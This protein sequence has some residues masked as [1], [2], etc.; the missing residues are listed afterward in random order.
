MF[1]INETAVVGLC[2][3]GGTYVLSL[4]GL[5]RVLSARIH[6]HEDKAGASHFVG[7]Y[8]FGKTSKRLFSTE[9]QYS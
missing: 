1:G 4:F 7:W 5:C 2:D 9:L 6:E 3:V 8:L